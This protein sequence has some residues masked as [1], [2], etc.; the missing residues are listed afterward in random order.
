MNRR[1]G[2]VTALLAAGTATA[3][4]VPKAEWFLGYNYVRVNSTTQIS[5]YSANGGSSQ[6]ALNFGKWV[7]GVFD[8]GGYH[9]GVV[10]G[11]EIDN[12]MLSYMFGPRINIRKGR[13]TPYFNTLFGGVWFGASAG[14]NVAPCTGTSCGSTTTTDRAAGSLNAFAM[15]VGG[16]VDIRLGKHVSFR[17]IGLDYFLTRLKNPVLQDDHNQHN[18]RY[19]AGISFLFGGERAAPPPPPPAPPAMRTC[20]DGSRI[21]MSEECPKRNMNPSLN[22]AQLELCPEGTATIRSSGIPPDATYEWTIDGQPISK[23]ATLDFGAAG[24][25]PGSY[26]IGLT[27]SA[28]DFNSASTVTTV[29]VRPWDAPTGTVSASPAEIWAGEAATI[30]ARFTPGHCGS[31]LETVSLSVPEGSIHGNQFDSSGVQFDPGDNRE[32][33]KTI[34]ITAK[35]TDARGSYTAETSVVVKKKAAIQA[36]RLPD[37]V[38]PQGNDRVN[39]C[40]KRVLLEQLRSEIERDPTGK[41]VLVGHLGPKETAA[42][43]D[44]KRALNAAAVLSAGQGVCYHL[45]PAQIMVSTTGAA[46]NGVDFQSHFCGTSATPKTSELPGQAVQETDANAKFRR[47]EVWFVPTGGSLPASVKQS[48]DAAS[49]SVSSLGC[50]K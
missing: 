42:G 43:L 23:A 13:V 49:M 31:E 18:L 38:F 29:V 4:D 50:P 15:A 21:P 36:S 46:D 47:V 11:Y 3:Q 34:Q 7:S 25:K 20:S 12:T 32:Q 45:A 6:L 1:Y 22:A 14:K 41:V 40:G 26:K 16:G 37:I 48:S 44:Q 19:S 27:A 10:N 33:R 28:P 9:N 24:R 39:N 8:I 2:L 30:T 35:T 5:S 17:P